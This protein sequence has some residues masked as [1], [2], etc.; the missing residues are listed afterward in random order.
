MDANGARALAERI[1]QE[2][3]RKAAAERE[4][5]LR[6]VGEP[7]AVDGD[8]AADDVADADAA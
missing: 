2:Q 3:R 8:A 1:A 4:A 6:A 5:A 7:D